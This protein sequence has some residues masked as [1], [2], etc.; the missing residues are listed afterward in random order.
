M[1]VEIR[2]YTLK[3]GMRNEFHKITSSVIPMLERWNINVVAIGPSLHDD[4]SYFLIR[5]FD[6]LQDREQKEEAFYTSNEWIH[7]PRDS[8]L[9]CIENYI[10]IVIPADQD[11][12]NKLKLSLAGNDLD[13]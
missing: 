12:I 5:S 3:S 1:V 2:T 7:G 8:V 6:S 10:T 13:K 11:L 4:D 9:A